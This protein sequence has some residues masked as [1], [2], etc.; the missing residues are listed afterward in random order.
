MR[1]ININATIIVP[2]SWE[3]AS[4]NERYEWLQFKLG[5][6]G[7]ISPS[8]ILYLEELEIEDFEIDSL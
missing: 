7:G 1:T 3:D 8:N 4:E 5:T 6:R 2:D